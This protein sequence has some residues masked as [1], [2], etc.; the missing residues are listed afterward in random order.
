M[1]TLI[2]RRRRGASAAG[3]GYGLVLVVGFAAVMWVNLPGHLTFDSVIALMQGRSGVQ[4]TWAPAPFAWALGLADRAHAGAAVYVVVVAAILF[5]SLLALPRLR[6]RISWAAPVLAAVVMLTPQVVLY[7]GIVWRDVLFANLVVAGFVLAAHGAARWS[8]GLPWASLLGAA[9]CLGVAAAVRQ[10]GVVLALAGVVAVA[11][12]ARG[13]GGRIWTWGLAGLV[14]VGLA[15]V[16]VMMIAQPPTPK[17]SLRKNTEVLI[18]QHYDV[19]GAAVREPGLKLSAIAAADPEAARI[20]E[21]NARTYYLPSRID[22]LDSDTTFRIALWRTP[23]PA[24]HAQWLDVVTDHTGAYLA[25][26]ADVFRWLIA[27]PDRK[28]C[29]PSAVGV[30]GPPEMLA[31]L[32]MKPRADA[33]DTDLHRYAN[34]V[35]PTPVYSHLVWALLGAA[36]VVF[37]MLRGDPA[38]RVM[39]ALVVGALAFAASFFVI[40]VACDYRYLYPLD[41]AVI[42]TLLYIAVDPSLRRSGR[43]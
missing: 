1:P 24:M 35:L 10:N 40:S 3:L 22:P 16:L 21:H 31:A 29:V 37:L 14:T 6:P 43:L 26:R 13:F 27:A 38:D 11:W 9:F 36:A 33:R 42:A 28:L 18:L 5:A 41:L 19:V 20:I 2:S 4:E 30:T 8:Q 23:D 25:H 17:T 7:Q 39:A 32:G 15:G 34:L 12:T